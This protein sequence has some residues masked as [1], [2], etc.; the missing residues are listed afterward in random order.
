MK[1]YNQPRRDQRQQVIEA[2][3]Q[4][5][6]MVVPEGGSLFQHNMTMVVDGHTGVE[7]SIPVA[8]DLRRRHAAV[9]PRRRSATRR[10]WSSATAATG[11]RT[12]GTRRRTSGRTSGCRSSCRARILDARSRRRTM[13]PRGRAATTSTTRAIAEGAARRRR[14]RAARRARPARGPRRAL[15]DV[16]VRAGRHDAASRRCA[17]RTLDG[18]RYLGLDRDIGS[19]E[20]GQARRPHRPRRQP[21]R[22]HPTVEETVRYTVVNGR[23]YDAATMNEIGPGRRKRTKY[24]W[25]SGP[26]NAP[27][28]SA[29]RS[30]TCVRGRPQGAPLHTRCAF[31]R[32]SRLRPA[33][34]G[35]ALAAAP[36]G[37]APSG[38][39]PRSAA[40]VPRRGIES[41]SASKNS[42][43]I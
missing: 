29:A 26:V 15:G 20:A 22:G 41:P 40:P 31:E 21:A 37:S 43:R 6:M 11:A 27:H 5:G 2:A 13:A 33:M 34:C 17:P 24:W 36:S 16:D 4:L 18:A 38:P 8:N 14:E 25:E 12:T 19:L 10:R 9:G 3:R 1:S 32:G 7:H 23:I 39:A 42:L 30:T 28:L 35:A